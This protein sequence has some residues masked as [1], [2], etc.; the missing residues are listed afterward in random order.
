MES[1]VTVGGLS[2]DRLA[3]YC[4]HARVNVDALNGGVPRG[5]HGTGDRQVALV[6]VL[7]GTPVKRTRTHGL[8]WSRSLV[9]S[10]KRDKNL[11]TRTNIRALARARMH[12]RNSDLYLY[13]SLVV[14]MYMATLL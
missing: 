10:G 6:W 13:L 11:R 8:A 12:A 1:R 2:W 5:T 7:R 9:I 4:M 3:R 14:S